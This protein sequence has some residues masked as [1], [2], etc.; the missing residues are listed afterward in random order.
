MKRINIPLHE[1]QRLYCEEN[2]SQEEIAKIFGVSQWIISKRMRDNHIER[3]SKTR[4]LS[5]RKYQ[6]NESALDILTPE[7]AWVLGWFL[8]DGFVDSKNDTFGIRLSVKDVDLLCKIKSLLEYT[9]PIIDTSTV[10]KKTGKLYKG[11]L[12]KITSS[13][14]KRKLIVYGIKPKKTSKETYLS[15]IN[16]EILDKHF[17][18]GVFEGDGSLLYYPDSK[19]YKFQIVGTLEL[20]SEIQRRL[21]SYLKVSLT[22]LHCQSARSNHYM[23]QYSGR[24][25]VLKIASWLYD[26]SKLHLDRKYNVYK[27][28]GNE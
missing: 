5:S 14:L 2:K 1:L 26:E 15:A 17:I 24:K 13:V 19:R 11:K 16:S 20:L 8:A 9:G 28:M 6:V 25:Q 22:K 27:E 12:L 23:M 21:V 18:K 7:V 10:L 4:N 3:K